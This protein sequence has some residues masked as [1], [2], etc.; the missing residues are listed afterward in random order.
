MEAKTT[1]ILTY[2][3]ELVPA[4]TLT[5]EAEADHGAGKARRPIR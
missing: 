1:G 5:V 3:L 2:P 4:V